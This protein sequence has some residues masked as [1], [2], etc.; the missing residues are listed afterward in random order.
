MSVGNR[1]PCLPGESEVDYQRRLRR[2]FHYGS[3]ID[4]DTFDDPTPAPS[5]F[6]DTG[7]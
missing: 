5:D 1:P 2:F 7:E 4:D 6:D 3:L